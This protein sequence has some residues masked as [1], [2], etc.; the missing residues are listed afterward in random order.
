[1]KTYAVTDGQFIKIGRA[2]D[3][4]KRIAAL[5]TASPRRLELVAT[6]RQDVEKA[7]HGRLRGEGIARV[8]GEWFRDCDELRKLLWSTG[9]DAISQQEDDRRDVELWNTYDNGVRVGFQRGIKHVMQAF[10]CTFDEGEEHW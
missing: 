10:N 6:H 9:F 5:Q 4:V 8:S 1:M 3:V 7:T 2:S